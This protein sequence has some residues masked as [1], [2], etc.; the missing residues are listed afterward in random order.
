M[1]KT[2][3]RDP[4]QAESLAEL[5]EILNEWAQAIAYS[6]CDPDCAGDP[7]DYDSDLCSLPTFGG[8]EP[9]NTS[10]V[11]SWDAE[12]IIAGGE[13]ITV[14]VSGWQICPRCPQCGEATFHCE[15]VAD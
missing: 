5:C 6:E 11:W 15:H 7:T 14:G 9:R 3:L 4:Q 10:E 12:S 2:D 13:D 1:T 8:P